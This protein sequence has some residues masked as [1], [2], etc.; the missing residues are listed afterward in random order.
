MV[1]ASDIFPYL[2]RIK[3]PAK[4]ICGTADQVTPPALN[5]KIAESIPGAEFATVEGAGHWL[6]LEYP[7][8]FNNALR[9]FVK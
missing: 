1:S 3:M 8:Q 4:V 6:F 2:P 9:A 7:E 5:R